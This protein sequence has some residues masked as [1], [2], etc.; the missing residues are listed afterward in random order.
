MCRAPLGRPV[1]EEDSDFD[2]N[3]ANQGMLEAAVRS[4]IHS[5]CD[6]SR[7]LELKWL[8]GFSLS[9]DIGVQYL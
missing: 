9:Q 1:E 3:E 6:L 2:I 7:E 8:S 5:R 4:G